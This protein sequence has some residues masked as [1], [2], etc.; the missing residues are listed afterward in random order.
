MNQ[1]VQNYFKLPEN[2]TYENGIFT[3]L[4]SKKVNNSI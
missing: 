3:F 4:Y 2:E 1:T